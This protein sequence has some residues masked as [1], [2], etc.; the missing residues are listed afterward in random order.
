MNILIHL[1]FSLFLSLVANAASAAAQ[2]FES[3]GPLVWKESE[4][5]TAC[6]KVGKLKTEVKNSR[7]ALLCTSAKG[8]IASAWFDRKHNMIGWLKRSR[9]QNGILVKDQEFDSKGLIKEETVLIRS[10]GKES[11]QIQNLFV[12]N[13][14]GNLSRGNIV[15]GDSTF[16]IAAPGL[17]FLN[18]QP[19][20]AEVLAHKLQ[21][22]FSVS[23]QLPLPKQ[24]QEIWQ[25]QNSSQGAAGSSQKPNATGAAK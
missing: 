19:T 10:M 6:Q 21:E 5:K 16:V 3:P 22:K 13:P 18:G 24:I 8:E 2:S 20:T 15:L 12:F 9:N 1:I 25:K 11:E 14:G 17:I 23:N 7:T 4:F